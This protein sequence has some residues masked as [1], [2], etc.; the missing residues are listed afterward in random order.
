MKMG[1]GL[2]IVEESHATSHKRDTSFCEVLDLGPS[3]AVHLQCVSH[4]D[5][6]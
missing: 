1:G 5:V 2:T 4:V 6:F 3:T